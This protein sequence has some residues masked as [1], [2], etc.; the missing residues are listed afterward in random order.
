MTISAKERSSSGAMKSRLSAHATASRGFAD[1]ALRAGPAAG[2][3]AAPFPR[4]DGA[5]GI[6]RGRP[7]NRARRTDPL[8]R[9]LAVSRLRG[10]DGLCGER[11]SP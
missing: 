5:I 6:S 11:F 3:E 2:R 10:G 1:R 4:P 7:E 8:R 9:G